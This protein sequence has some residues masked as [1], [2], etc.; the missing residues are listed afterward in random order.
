MLTK[1]VSIGDS[2]TVRPNSW[3]E[4]ADIVHLAP[5]QRLF[6]DAWIFSNDD[7]ANVYPSDDIEDL[8]N[9]FQ[10]IR[11]WAMNMLVY[12]ILH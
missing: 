12:T 6:G 11:I 7:D 1:L 5:L 9:I 2:L 4:F 10:F 8:I 3:F